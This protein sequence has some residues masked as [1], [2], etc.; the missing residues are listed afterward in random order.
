LV[1]RDGQILEQGERVVLEA[2]PDSVFSQM[3]QSADQ[4]FMA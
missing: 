1:L 4:E 3:L 2:T